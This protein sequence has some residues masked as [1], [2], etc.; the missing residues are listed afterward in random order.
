MKEETRK[1][2]AVIEYDGTNYSGF[3]WQ[4][5]RST[6][7]GELER[8][9][10][11]ITQEQI[12][13]IGAGRT[14]AGVHACGQVIHLTTVWQRGCD[15][16]Q[17]AVN[18]LLP[19]DIVVRELSHVDMGFHARYSAVSR[20][21]RYVILDQPLRSPLYRNYAY[22][23]STPVDLMA[24]RVAGNYLCGNQSFEAFASGQVDQPVR[25]I[26]ALDCSLVDSFIYVDLLINGAFSHLVR[27]IVGSLLWV[28]EG[29][30]S[31]TEFVTALRSEDRSLA[32][33]KAPPQGLYLV[34]VNY[35]FR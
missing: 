28:G 9:L 15:E 7:Q 4:P 2:R 22:H 20:H 35:G 25:S 27:R 5:D 21:Y 31:I 12:R 33:P 13:I 11:Q 18:A 34:K 23:Y 10:L 30:M 17:R 32:A 3:Q 14:D 16:L 26:Y 29:R 6:I 8:V 19:R 24:M 1:F